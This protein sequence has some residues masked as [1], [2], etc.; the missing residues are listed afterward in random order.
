MPRA[1][2]GATRASGPKKEFGDYVLRVD[3][4]LK[5]ASFV[6]RNVPCILPDGSHARDDQGKEMRLAIPDAD[7]GILLRGSGNHQVNIWCWPI[8]PGEL[9]YGPRSDPETPAGLRT[10]LTPST[11]AEKP[12]GELNGFA[13]TVHR[14]EVRVVL[15]EKRVIPG[16]YLPGFKS[17]GPIGLQHHG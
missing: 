6:N 8:G 17:S 15:N 16:A 5:E 11:Q 2:R 4:R 13:I 1:K 3:W 14:D 10:S 12:V 9:M 7:S